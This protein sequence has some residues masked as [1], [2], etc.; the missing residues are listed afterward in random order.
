MTDKERRDLPKRLRK[1]VDRVPSKS[2]ECKHWMLKTAD[3]LEKM[4]RTVQKLKKEAGNNPL[5]KDHA[6]GSSIACPACR[7]KQA[8]EAIQRMVELGKSA[9]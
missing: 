4:Q 2:G 5:C 3:E 6:K 8:E 9:I 1:L 7:L